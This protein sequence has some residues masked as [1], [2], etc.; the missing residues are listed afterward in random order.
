MSDT[1]ER[2]AEL[3]ERARRD[4]E[5]FVPPEDPPDEQRAL[6]YLREGVAPTVA[7]Y[8]EARTG[9]GP[10]D[11]FAPVEFSLLERALNDWLE[12]YAACYGVDIDA[13]FTV[14]EAAAVLLE[15]HDVRD[16]AQLLTHVPDR[17]PA[18]AD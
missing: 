10:P 8:V 13:A 16:V 18:R 9:E 15:T 1:R 5:S 4:R 17:R 11:R 2:V 12:L 6:T 3:A 7:V 14:R